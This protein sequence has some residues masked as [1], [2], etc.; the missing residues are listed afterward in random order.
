MEKLISLSN[1]E[2]I[3]YKY[4]AKKG[5]ERILN[6]HK[7]VT[8]SGKDELYYPKVNTLKLNNTT[9]HEIIFW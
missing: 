3:L 5:G 1:R 4:K 2:G 9:M 8:E 6:S 7:S